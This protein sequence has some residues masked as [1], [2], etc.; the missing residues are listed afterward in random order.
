MK[1]GERGRMAKEKMRHNFVRERR[2][3]QARVLVV[4]ETTENRG[5][6]ITERGNR[7]K[8]VSSMSWV[9][10]AVRQGYL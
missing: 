9:K 3:V 6:G 2:Q 4:D 1:I 10:K 8:C 5:R 7:R